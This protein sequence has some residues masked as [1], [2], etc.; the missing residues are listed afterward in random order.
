MRGARPPG[1]RGVGRDLGHDRP[2]ARAR[3]SRGARR[4]ARAT[5]CCFASVRVGATRRRPTSQVPVQPDPR[6]SVDAAGSGGVF[7]PV[8]ETTEELPSSASASSRTLRDLAAARGGAG[9]LT[10]Q[11]GVLA[12]AARSGGPGRELRRT[13]RSR[14]SYRIDRADGASGRATLSRG[15]APASELPREPARAACRHARSAARGPRRLGLGHQSSV[16]AA[17]QGM[18]ASRTSTGL[19][20]RGCRRARWKTRRRGSRRRSCPIHA[21]RA[22]SCLGA[23]L[24][25]GRRARCG[26][27][28]RA[29]ASLTSWSRSPRSASGP[30]ATRRHSKEE[31]RRAGGAGGARPRAKTAFFSNVSHEFRTP[32]TLHA[33]GRWRTPLAAR[34]ARGAAGS[35][36]RTRVAH[37]NSLR[38]L[39]PRATTMLDFSRIEAGRLARA[40]IGRS[41]LA[42]RTTDARRARSAPHARAPGS[43]LADR[44]PAA[45]RAGYV[46][47]DMWRRSSPNLRQQTRFKFTLRG[48]RSRCGCATA[49]GR[50]LSL[51][52]RTRASASRRT[53][54]RGCSSASTASSQAGRA[55]R[56]C[57][58]RGIGLA[59]RQTS[60]WQPARRRGVRQRARE[61]ERCSRSRCRSG[62][63]HLRIRGTSAETGPAATATGS[64]GVVAGGAPLAAGRRAGTGA[65]AGDA[66][67]TGR[68]AS[69]ARGPAPGRGSCGRTTTRTCAYLRRAALER[70]LRRRV[71]SLR[72]DGAGAGA[73]RAQPAGP[74]AH[75]RHDAGPRRRRPSLRALVTARAHGR[76]CRWCCCPREPA[77]RAAS[78]AWR[79]GADRLSR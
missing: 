79:P 32:L 4:H 34:E 3:R 65:R 31:R 20:G 26:R 33:V 62:P 25:R 68:Y 48:H 49:E 38:L 71:A 37:R 59:P 46:D 42:R 47:L 40:P 27:S 1:R 41:D 14:R 18:P 56:T 35:A 72:Q 19:R 28:T 5:S 30:P 45:R 6:Q 78:R 53:S 23:V 64:R 51:A 58:D 12:R 60:S 77:R 52:S 50:R 70:A 69:V 55:D 54:C 75:G 10:R 39:R 15:S 29:T 16:R 21:V 63:L 9:R 36:G 2:D 74:G 24:D 11:T 66:R 67:R 8:I 76:L 43:T 22:R 44:L 7:C 73:R 13:C 17:R 57:R 61:G